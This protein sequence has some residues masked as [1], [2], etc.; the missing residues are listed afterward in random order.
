M[1][2]MKR[3]PGYWAVIPANIR[4]DRT[5]TNTAKLLYGEISSLAQMDG[6]C[7]ATDKYFADLFICS[8]S[9]ISRA[10]RSLCE[11]GYIRIEK[12]SNIKGAERHIFCGFYP[13]NLRE[14][15][16]VK[17]DGTLEGTRKNDG[18]GP[19]KNDGTPP[20][21]PINR[22][23][24]RGN[25][26]ARGNEVREEVREA[27]SSFVSE[28][29]LGEDSA[30]FRSLM[31]FAENRLKIGKSMDTDLAAR[32]LTIKLYRLSE[33]KVPVMIAMLDKAIELNWTSVYALRPDELPGSS[34]GSAGK[35]EERS[36]V[37]TWTPGGGGH[38]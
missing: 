15:G 2:E 17:N 1:T 5:L 13:E 12:T 10:I 29:G 19:V 6:Y 34:G 7:W 35:V 22:N 36:G 4:Y 27:F 23:T 33:G 37:K 26:R 16:P 31:D 14:G 18:R 38:G 32:R 24:K 11:G 30:L 3:P 21:T 25:T 9:T 20:A 28:V 8:E